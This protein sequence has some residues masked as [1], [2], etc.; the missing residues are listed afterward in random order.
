MAYDV[1]ALASYTKDEAKQLSYEKIAQGDM[2]KYMVI[3]TGIK[4]AERINAVATTAH[5][6]AGGSCGFSASG[7]TVFSQRTIT[8]GKVKLNLKWCEQ[9]LEAKYLQ[10]AVK[11]GSG[12]KLDMLTFKEEL[13]KDIEQKNNYKVNRAIWLGNTASGDASINKFDGLCKIIAAGVGSG[14]V[15]ATPV[16]WSVAN[17][18]TAMQNVY[19]ALTDD[20]LANP[21]LKVFMGLSEARDYR[22]KLGIDNLYHITGTEAKL[23]IENTD[24]EIVP[25]LGLSGT[26]KVYAIATDNMFL[27]TDMDGEY[28][29]YDLFYAK[30]ADEIRYVNEFKMG[31][32]V[33]FL[34]QIVSQQNT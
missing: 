14:V 2:A 24:V 7:E 18:R 9:D 32:Q 29:K 20:M 34:D 16:A 30:E 11:T 10:M 25:V 23:Y 13:L 17:S 12:S 3:Q 21:N 28:E 6:Q 4:S 15:S 1:S 31:T 5:W 33:Q 26:K 22:M 27:G 19:A 8:V